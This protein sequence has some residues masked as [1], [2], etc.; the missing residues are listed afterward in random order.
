MP[1]IFNG[2]EE[3]V[4]TLSKGEGCEARGV[5]QDRELHRLQQLPHK[6]DSQTW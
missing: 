5:R 2:F 3:V 1:S 4:V 6:A